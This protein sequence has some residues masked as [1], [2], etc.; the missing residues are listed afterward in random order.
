MN[1][2]IIYPANKEV[3][4]LNK[5]TH[6][7]IEQITVCHDSINYIKSA[8]GIYPKIR[9][10]IGRMSERIYNTIGDKQLNINAAE[11]IIESIEYDSTDVY[12]GQPYYLLALTTEQFDDFIKYNTIPTATDTTAVIASYSSSI[13]GYTLD[14]DYFIT[15]YLRNQSVEK[16][17]EI[18]M[19]LMPVIVETASTSTGA[20]SV[21]SIKPLTQLAA[22]TIRSGKN[23]YSPMRLKILYNG[24]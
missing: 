19:I 17:D 5:F 24:F 11:I 1:T 21:T 9:I 6:P 16:D 4:Q 20:T 7:N 22:T 23:E 3:R 12:M 15:K 8:A 13:N 10:P 14:L 18:E 2:S